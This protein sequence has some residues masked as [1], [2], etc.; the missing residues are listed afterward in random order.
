MTSKLAGLKFL[1]FPVPAYVYVWQEFCGNVIVAL[2]SLGHTISKRKTNYRPN[3]RTNRDCP[4]YYI[5]IICGSHHLRLP[6]PPPHSTVLIAFGL[7]FPLARA[8]WWK[9]CGRRLTNSN[10]LSTCVCKSVLSI[11]CSSALELMMSRT[12][13]QPV[14]LTKDGWDW[15]KQYI[16]AN[17]QQWNDII[18]TTIFTPDIWTWRCVVLLWIIRIHIHSPDN[19]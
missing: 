13:G 6:P 8:I 11:V 3:W 12:D 2:Y 19:I 10:Y 9:L 18:G 7:F 4:F 5:I 15:L 1:L 14:G 16:M 17:E